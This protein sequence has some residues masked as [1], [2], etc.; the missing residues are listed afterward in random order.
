MTADDD[1][2]AVLQK[3]STLSTFTQI[4][5]ILASPRQLQKA[6]Q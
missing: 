3:F 6:A 4:D 5:G 2:I 1:F